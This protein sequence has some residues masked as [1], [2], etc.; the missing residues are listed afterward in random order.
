MKITKARLR[1]IIL[2]ELQTETGIQENDSDNVF[3]PNHYCIHHGGVEHDGRIEMAEAV[4]HVVPDA[5]GY[6]SHYDMR[7]ASGVI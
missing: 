5:D 2:E 3:A 4:Q 6:I 7:L 1:E